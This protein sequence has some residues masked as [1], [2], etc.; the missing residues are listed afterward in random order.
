MRELREF[1]ADF[2]LEFA[3]VATLEFSEVARA[4]RFVAGAASEV[5]E[6]LDARMPSGCVV[7]V[8]NGVFRALVLAGHVMFWTE[9][10]ARKNSERASLGFI[11]FSL[12][13]KLEWPKIFGIDRW[14][15]NSF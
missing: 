3:V 13:V 12:A 5:L 2:A 7:M 15:V 10:F 1:F 8:T 9:I 4:E 14:T 6:S 11:S